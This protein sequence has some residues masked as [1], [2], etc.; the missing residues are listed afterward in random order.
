MPRVLLLIPSATYRAPDFVAA[1]QR[2]EIELVVG[3]EHGS[4]LE[5][6][7]EGRTLTVDL[8]DPETGARQ[9]EAFALQY[10]VD[11][12]VAVDDAGAL[13]VPPEGAEGEVVGDVTDDVEL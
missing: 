11:T 12:V 6:V 5:G 2:L 3:S 1:A 10:P 9:I 13:A 4:P 7:A 8:N